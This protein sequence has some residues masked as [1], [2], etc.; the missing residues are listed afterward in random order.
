[1][2]LIS[3]CF[4]GCKKHGYQSCAQLAGLLVL[5]VAAVFS[6]AALTASLEATDL[7]STRIVVSTEQVS[8]PL[9]PTDKLPPLSFSDLDFQGDRAFVSERNGRIYLLD[10][11]RNRVFLDVSAT[12]P[13][14]V[15]DSEHLGLLGV[16]FHPAFST[17]RARG[18][19][20]LYSACRRMR[21]YTRRT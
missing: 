8:K 11:R 2:P 13:D 20:K 21:I 9:T 5:A 7:V 17:S 4:R 15:A 3:T 16:A 10:A 19:G 6:N 1:M 12:R 14:F 18:C